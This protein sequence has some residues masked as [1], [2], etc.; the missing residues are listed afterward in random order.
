MEED[1][2]TAHYLRKGAIPALYPLKKHPGNSRLYNCESL[3]PVRG[4]EY[5]WADI[6]AGDLSWTV[7]RSLADRSESLIHRILCRSN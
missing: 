7:D 3:Q 5:R 1:F 4:R 6:S 2:S